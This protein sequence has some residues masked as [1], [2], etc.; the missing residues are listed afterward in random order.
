MRNPQVL[1]GTFLGS[2]GGWTSLFN[3]LEMVQY[4]VLFREIT[5]RIFMIMEGIK[6][7]FRSQT[8]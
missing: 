7:G 1:R 3:A 4:V 6:L 5:G 8:R 2:D